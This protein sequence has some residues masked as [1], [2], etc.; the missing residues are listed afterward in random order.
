VSAKVEHCAWFIFG[1]SGKFVQP[2]Y[3]F[4]VEIAGQGQVGKIFYQGVVSALKNP[5]EAIRRLRG[6]RELPTRRQ[7]SSPEKLTLAMFKSL[8]RDPG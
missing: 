2:A 7:P 1:E 4:D 8:K 5:P 6:P 3:H